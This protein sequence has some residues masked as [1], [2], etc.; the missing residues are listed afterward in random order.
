MLSKFV[1]ALV[2]VMDCYIL[3][4]QKKINL[5]LTTNLQSWPRWWS[6]GQHSCLQL[7]R[8]KFDSCWLL[9]KFSVRKRRKQTKKRPGLAH[10]KKKSSIRH[11]RCHVLLC[12]HLME[13]NWMFYRSTYFF[14][15]VGVA[16]QLNALQNQLVLGLSSWTF[17]SFFVISCQL[18][19]SVS[20][21]LHQ[22]QS[23]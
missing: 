11:N 14:W 20:L 17:F 1:G 18:R 10:L 15:T 8:S 7:R 2:P 19:P 13:P 5:A 4:S 22:G 23:W 6:S 21:G 12:S 16:E 9:N 3:T